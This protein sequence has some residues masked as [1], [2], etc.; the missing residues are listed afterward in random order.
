[1]NAAIRPRVS[2][3]VTSLYRTLERRYLYVG[4]FLRMLRGLMHRTRFL[5][6]EFLLTHS[7]FI[8]HIIH[9]FLEM[10]IR[11]ILMMKDFSTRCTFKI[12]VCI[13][14]VFNHI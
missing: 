6:E 5:K 8:L 11:R 12:S 14:R 1:M 3:I 9:M 4:R 13:P 7:T 10:I 2:T